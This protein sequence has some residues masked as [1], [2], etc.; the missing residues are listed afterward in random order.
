M[1]EPIRILHLSDLHFRKDR[2]E[3]FSD[4]LLG[5]GDTVETMVKDGKNPD[6]VVLTGDLVWSGKSSDYQLARTWIDQHLLKPIK[7]FRK[8]NLLV[9][10][11]NHDVNRKK[12]SQAAEYIEEGLRKGDQHE[13]TKVLREVDTRNLVLKRQEEYLKFANGYRPQSRPL[14]VPWWSKIH[15]CDS[16]IS[17]GFAGLATS[18]IAYG[19]DERDYGNLLLGDYQIHAMF[20]KLRKVNVRIALIHHPVSYLI[21]QERRIVLRCL[22]KNCSIL[23]RGHL[24]EQ[25]SL[26]YKTED[27]LMVELAT[28]SA[29]HD[30]RYDNNFQV[31]E[32][33]TD[34]RTVVVQYWLWKNSS[35]IID[36]NAYQATDGY[37]EFPLRMFNESNLVGRAKDAEAAG[38]TTEAKAKVAHE[39]VKIPLAWQAEKTLSELLGVIQTKTYKQLRK[40]C[41]D[42]RNNQIR[43]NVFLPDYH[44]AS[45][46]EDVR[47]YIPDCFRINMNYESEWSIRFPPGTGATGVTF[48]DGKPRYTRRISKKAGEWE[49]K[50]KMTKKLRRTVHKDLKWILSVPLVD[51]SDSNTILGVMNIDGLHHVISESVVREVMVKL[52]SEELLPFMLYL[53]KRPRETVSF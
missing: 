1:A 49:S 5:L 15:R 45:K 8:E 46:F 28:G 16:G 48:V 4:V 42:L 26:I 39:F 14:E 52:Y 19:N 53:S 22:L 33:D 27:D 37:S 34:K 21:G 18:L 38:V 51:P 36:R 11:G 50:L 13:I 3:D 29:Y 43:A 35:W 44:D 24:H 30:R 32:I 10:P 6:F 2:E 17:I 9:I 41:S 31:I 47:L 7:G 12:I 25:D 20:R 23:L 40:K